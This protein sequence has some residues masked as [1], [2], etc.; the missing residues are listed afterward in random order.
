MINRI[1]SL[2]ENKIERDSLLDLLYKEQ[3]QEKLPHEKSNEEIEAKRKAFLDQ[4]RQASAVFR[5]ACPEQ[6]QVFTNNLAMLYGTCIALD[7]RTP[8]DLLGMSQRTGVPMDANFYA[9][10]KAY[11]QGQIEILEGIATTLEV[12]LDPVKAKKTNLVK[13]LLTAIR[14]VLS[15]D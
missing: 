11:N 12:K 3:K 8:Y 2:I 1:P 10:V 9:L 6:W 15:S 14:F 13:K 7:R 5:G 4:I